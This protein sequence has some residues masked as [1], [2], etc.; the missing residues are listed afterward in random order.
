M[1]GMVMVNVPAGEFKMGS[2]KTVDAQAYDNELPQHTVY[3]DAYWIDKTLV[4]NGM[5]TNCVNAGSCTVPDNTS[6]RTRSD[7]YSSSQYAD[8]PVIFVDWN[9]VSAYCQWAGRRLPTEAEWEKAARGTDGRI[10]PWGNGVPTCSLANFS[11]C[12]GDTSAVD[13]HPEGASLYGVLDMAGNV[14]E[15]VADWY[16]ETYYGESPANNPTGPA[17]GDYRVLRGGSWVKNVQSV[18]SADRFRLNPDLGDDYLGFRCAA[19]P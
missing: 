5:Y 1:D 10:F 8:Y 2:D 9:Q 19:S 16:S 18:R 14:W 11:G 3:L 6:S 13:S 12:G 7:Y 15:W 17:T 4:T